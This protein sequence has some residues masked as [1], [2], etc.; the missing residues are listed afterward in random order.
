[1][2]LKTIVEMLI[3]RLVSE[4]DQVE[5]KENQGETTLILEAR[6][7]KQDMGKMIGRKGKTIEAL[8]TI[9]GACATKQS[10]RCIFQLIEDEETRSSFKS[11]QNSN[12]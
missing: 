8:R 3:K 2:E 10:Q 5:V 6:V 11:Q 7:A 9:L 1:M 12:F 4:P